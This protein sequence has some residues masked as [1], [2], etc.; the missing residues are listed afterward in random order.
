MEPV[1]NHGM[2]SPFCKPN[3]KIQDEGCKK[4]SPPER[5]ERG[6]EC[7]KPGID[8]A[9]IE[10]SRAVSAARVAFHEPCQVMGWCAG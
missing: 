9:I 8:P 2:G 10:E 3:E 6:Q 5:E 4:N 1:P 7:K